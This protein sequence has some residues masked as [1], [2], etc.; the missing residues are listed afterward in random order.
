MTQVCQK[1]TT[2]QTSNNDKYINKEIIVNEVVAKLTHFTKLYGIT[3]LFIVGG[4]T[5]E[6]YAGKLWRVNDIDV[7][8]AFDDEAMQL[9]G[10]FAS[11][12]L[13]VVPKVY[14]RSGAA[15]V[16]YKSPVGS[17][18]V[19]FQGK[20]SH[21]YMQQED[22]REWMH[23]KNIEDVPLM[24]NIYGRDF[25][26]NSMIYSLSTDKLMDPTNR[27]VKDIERKQII[28]L[29]PA[30]MLIRYNP[31]AILRAIRFAILYNFHIHADLSEAIKGRLSD[32]QK[33]LSEERITNEVIRIL[34]LDN[35]KGVELLQRFEL[36]PLLR[37]SELRQ[38]LEKEEDE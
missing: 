25:T 13:G 11:E 28:S 17:I 12:E 9:G 7:A 24:N 6:L 20:S 30:E 19:E 22:V 14:K 29:L 37:N 26:I 1:I 2:A 21:G 16:E 35:V 4:Y 27:A 34:E 8:S 10:L 38:Y 18:K 15:M 31:L 5:R 32:L 33:S 36:L 23:S 3:S